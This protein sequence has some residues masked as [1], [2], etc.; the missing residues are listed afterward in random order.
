MKNVKVTVMKIARYDDL[1]KIYENPIEH[2]CDMRL[3]QSFVCR[4]G[5]RP[6]GFCD[7]A[8]ESV[9]P[10]LRELARGGGNFY[11][12]WMKDPFSAMISCNDGF[13]PV[14]F[15]LE[16]EEKDTTVLGT[17]RM[18]LRPWELADAEELYRYASDPDVGY[19]AG[20]PA[21]KSVDESAQIIKDI[22]AIPETYAVCLKETGHPVGSISLIFGKRT[23][24]AETDDECELGYWLGK[25]YWGRGLMPEAAREMLR[26]AFADLGLKKVWGGY[27]DGNVKSKRVQ[28]KCGFKYVRTTEDVEVPQLGE[29]RRG[30]VNCI[31]KEEWESREER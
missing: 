14:S 19:P 4:D 29:T 5:R 24:L 26:H 22:L 12:G 6:D 20:W 30:H 23:D 1:M 3:G 21:H 10:F 2:A 25:P 16:A 13:R 11:D 15:L 18:T 7:S 8:W 9:L 17:E 27:Y 28:E 31:T